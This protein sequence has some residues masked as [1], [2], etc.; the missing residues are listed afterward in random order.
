MRTTTMTRAFLL[1]SGCTLAACSEGAD[2]SDPST[3]GTFGSGNSGGDTTDGDEDDPTG[4]GHSSDGDGDSGDGDGDSGDGDG[5]SGDGDGDSG[6]G[7]GDG[8]SGDGDSG[9][10]DGDSGDGDGDSGEDGNESI[11]CDVPEAELAPV[12]PHVVLVLDKSGSMIQNTWDHDANGQTP[13]VTRWKSLHN[14][15]STI[16]TNFDDQFEFGAQLYP[17]TDATN[18]YSI[19]ACLVNT[20]PEVLVA[21]NNAVDVLLGIPTGTSN[22]IRGGTPAAAGMSSAIDHLVAIDDGDPAAIILV[23]D[24]AANC[25]TDAASQFDRFETYDPNLLPL[26][27][28]A[29]GDL[30]IPTYVVGIDIADAVTGITNGNIFP[31]NGEPDG[32]NPFDKLNELAVAGGKPL[33][34]AA[35]FYQTQNEIELQDAIQAIVDDAASC[36]LFLDPV[37]VFPDLVEVEMD[38]ATVP[39]VSDCASEDGW[40]F[41]NPNGPY[42]SL[43]LC[44][45]WCEQASDAAQLQALY[46]CDPG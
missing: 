40:V 35:D 15:V 18:E 24:G 7:D 9:D 12:V 26:V 22:N 11:P 46:Y 34:G 30:G 27:A 45:S 21:P 14:V 44:G 16:V 13:K 38:G 1:A 33:G 29:Y 8:D 17:S 36:T 37:P 19:D 5:D 28:D 2:T 25:R 4:D 43:E 23:T 31:P 6:D 20:P 41:S 32:I 39:K 10:G 42:Q 3:F